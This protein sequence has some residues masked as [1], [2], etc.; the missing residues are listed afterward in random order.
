[1]TR[2]EFTRISVFRDFPGHPVGKTSPSSAGSWGSYAL[3]PKKQKINQ[4]QYCNKFNKGLK[5]GPHQKKN[6]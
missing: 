1:M 5:N 6:L 2:T 3:Q 4:K